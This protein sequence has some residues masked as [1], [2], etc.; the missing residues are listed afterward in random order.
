MLKELW[1]VSHSW[2][3]IGIMLDIEEGQLRK[4]KADN[5]HSDHCLREMLR[6]WFKNPT[7]PPTWSALIAAIENAGEKKLAKELKEKY[8]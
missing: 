3:N 4:I 1:D 2:E 6:I 5:R 7:S 8:P